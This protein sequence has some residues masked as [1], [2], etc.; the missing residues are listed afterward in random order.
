MSENDNTN[1]GSTSNQTN[2]PN[3]TSTSNTSTTLT[4]DNGGGP[5]QNQGV[6]V[7]FGDHSLRTSYDEEQQQ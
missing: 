6:Q 7:N 3:N 4:E 1:N 2:T 5:S